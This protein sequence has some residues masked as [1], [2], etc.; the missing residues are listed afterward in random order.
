MKKSVKSEFGVPCTREYQRAVS[1][2]KFLCRF[3][4]K[5]KLF[6]QLKKDVNKRK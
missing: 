1:A 2:M 6:E 4:S 3:H 5:R